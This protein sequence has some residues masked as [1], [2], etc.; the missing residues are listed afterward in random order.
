MKKIITLMLTFTTILSLCACSIS[1]IQDSDT[2][3]VKV[4]LPASFL[5]EEEFVEVDL[6]ENLSEESGI[7]S[8][9]TNNDGSVT[10]VLTREKQKEWIEEAKAVIDADISTIVN[11]GSYG[12]YSVN[13][14]QDLTQF[15]IV[16]FFPEIG[17]LDELATARFFT[18]GLYYNA[19]AGK[20]V[21]DVVVVF[22]N[23]E[24]GE[25]VSEFHMKDYLN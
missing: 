25:K 19:F 6:N 3:N 12:Y 1:D 14:N 21:N 10:F 5:E 9:K 15:D 8:Q 23:N 16:T 13:Y 4:T 24:S 2:S 7:I 18:Y 22:T 11:D 17:P 20:A